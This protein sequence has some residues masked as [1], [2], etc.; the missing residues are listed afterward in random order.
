MSILITGGAGYIGSHMVLQLLNE[1]EKVVVLDN[2]STGFH[3]SVPPCA[4]FVKGDVGDQELVTN[5][6]QDHQVT[7]IVHFAASSVVPESLRDPMG[8]Y[9]NNTA[10][11][12]ALIRTALK[13]GIKHFVFSSTAAVYGVTD[14]FVVTED[15]PKKPISPYG[16]SKLM[17]EKM[18]SDAAA[19]H[20]FNYVALR[21]FN[22]AGADPEGRIGQS[23]PNATHLI[24]V[25]CQASLGLRPYLEIFGSDYDTTDGTGIRDY[26]HVS[27]LVAAHSATLCYLRNG[28]RS[29]VLNC[30]Y[31]RGSSVLEIVNSVKQAANRDFRLK[32][33]P[34]RAGDP[35]ALIAN[36]EKIRKTL[37]W[38]PQYNDL[39]L[40]TRH[41]LHWEEH[42]SRE[43]CAKDNRL[44]AR[45]I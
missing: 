44:T 13:Q 24:K 9:Y 3:W 21:Y 28:G 26:I 33:S 15:T 4:I 7:A 22:V 5:I 45:V 10:K 35:A 8:Y 37:D 19:S 25:A 36:T 42:L 16:S 11:S 40:I 43:A 17:I 30:G 12:C 41:A 1:Q 39:D 20:N 23:T 31:G 14:T 6:I 32:Y 34:R 27:D 2:L 38:R 29:E 18:L